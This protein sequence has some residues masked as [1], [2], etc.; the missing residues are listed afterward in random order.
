MFGL[1]FGGFTAPW[2]FLLLVLV[3]AIIAGYVLVQRMRR[4]RTMRFTNLELLEKV[5][6]KRQNWLPTQVFTIRTPLA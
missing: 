3:A 6:P 2:W 4:K 5:V 1:S